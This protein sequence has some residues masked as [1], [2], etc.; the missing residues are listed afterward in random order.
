MTRKKGKFRK[1]CGGVAEDFAEDFPRSHS[2]TPE[3]PSVEQ[4]FFPLHRRTRSASVMSLDDDENSSH[5]LPDSRSSFSHPQKNPTDV[6]GPLLSL[7]PVRS[8]P[9]VSDQSAD[10][11]APSIDES[12]I[13]CSSHS[14]TSVAAE[15]SSAAAATRPPELTFQQKILQLERQERELARRNQQRRQ[16]QN[17]NQVAQWVQTKRAAAEQEKRLSDF[18]KA[19]IER[20]FSET[21]SS[22]VASIQSQK[23]CGTVVVE[24]EGAVV[25]EHAPAVPPAELV[26]PPPPH[27]PSLAESGRQLTHLGRTMAVR[28]GTRHRGLEIGTASRSH[29]RAQSEPGLAIAIPSEALVLRGEAFASVASAFLGSREDLSKPPP[30]DHTSDHDEEV[31]RF[32]PSE[33]EVFWPK[34]GN[35]RVEEVP[36]SVVGHGTGFVGANAAGVLGEDMVG[37][38]GGGGSLPTAQGGSVPPPLVKEENGTFIS[39]QERQYLSGVS[40]R[41][42]DIVQAWRGAP[43]VRRMFSQPKLLSA[44]TGRPG[45][46][47]SE[48]VATDDGSQDYFAFFGL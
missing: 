39:A 44:R 28:P 21:S 47:R 7:T 9:T 34:P 3:Q 46:E 24:Q 48:V 32:Q 23:N 38:G 1:K 25:N 19:G 29:D 35:K 2:R 27:L 20:L 11:P 26:L 36:V 12:R 31:F 13:S 33:R 8:S 16:L 18:H 43:H 30:D 22:S 42:G 41:V 6:H 37:V 45:P 14:A 15:R 17:Q 4:A 40:S 5:I 10:A